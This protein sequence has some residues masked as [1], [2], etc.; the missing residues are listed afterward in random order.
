VQLEYLPVKQESGPQVPHLSQISL[1]VA[2]LVTLD[3]QVLVPMPNLKL[4]LLT[5][6]WVSSDTRLVKHSP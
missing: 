6:D 2:T 1:L 3:L 5:L 4:L